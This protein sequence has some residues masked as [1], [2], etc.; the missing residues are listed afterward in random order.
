MISSAF[1]NG[2]RGPP[3]Q[4]EGANIARTVANELDSAKFDPLLVQA[5]AKNAATSLENFVNRADALVRLS[6]F[7]VDSNVR[8]YNRVDC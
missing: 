4:P 7:L 1:A 5:V 2:A 3:G 6:P 8:P